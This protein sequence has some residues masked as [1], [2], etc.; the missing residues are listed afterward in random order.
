MADPRMVARDVA[1]V[2][3]VDRERVVRIWARWR[4]MPVRTDGVVCR[5]AESVGRPASPL[6]RVAS[7]RELR[8]RQALQEA[9]LATSE[10]PS[11]A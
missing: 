1:V 9:V 11:R 2:K 3:V 7:Q 4:S 6:A 10:Q 8:S 5:A